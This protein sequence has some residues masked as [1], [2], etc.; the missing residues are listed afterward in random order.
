MKCVEIAKGLA[1]AAAL[2]SAGCMWAADKTAK[3]TF[4]GDLM[5]Q[6]G[7]LEPYRT[8][9]GYDF[10]DVFR[11]LKPLFAAS[12][13]V[14]GNLETPIAPDDQDLTHARWE[15]CSPRAFAQAVKDAGV[16][17]VFT[18][19]NHCLDRGPAGVVRTLQALD[20]VGLRHTGTF[21]TKADSEKPEIVEVKGFRLGLL[22]YT[23]GS[24]AFSNNQYLD[25][26]NRHLVNFFQQ[27]ELSPKGA[28][29]WQRGDRE[30]AEAKAYEAWEKTH[31]PDNFTLPVYERQEPHD[32]ERAKIKADVARTKAAKPD[33][34]VV[35]MHTG[36]Q[37]NPEATKYT[38]E[39]TDFLFGCGVDLVAGSHEH[40]VHGGDFAGLAENRLATYSLGN[41]NGLNG[42]WT[43]PFG[44]MADYSIAWHLYLARGADGKARVEKT[45]FTVLKCVKDGGNRR[46]R[47]V[48]AAELYIRETDRVARRKLRADILETARRFCGRDFE[49][50][51]VALEYP[52]SA[53]VRVDAQVPAG[54][55]VV[56]KVEGD[57]VRVRPDLRD[58]QG[59]WFY[60]AFRVTGAA[61]RKLAFKFGGAYKG[62]VVGTR[63]PVVSFDKGRT[64]AYACE[65]TCTQTGFTYAF[66]QDADEVW[67]YECH[68]YH[69]SDWEAFLARHA[70]D[71]GK[72]F[73]TGVLC[74]TKKGRAVEKARFGCL[75]G[76]PKYTMLLTSRHHASESVATYALEGFLEAVLAQDEL[77]AWLRANVEV[78]TVPFMDKD[79]CVDGDQGKN[80]KPHDHNRDYTEFLHPETKATVAWIKERTDNRLDVWIDLH[81]P[82]IRGPY[83][84]FVYSPLKR[85][86]NKRN[87]A[88]EIRF[89][90]L[91]EKLQCGSLNYKASDDLPYGKAWNTG[92]NYAKGWSSINWA[93]NTLPGIRLG[94]TFEIPFAT[95]N[96]ATVTPD[97]VRAL[98]RDIAKTLKAFLEAQ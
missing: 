12:D 69:Q 91:L 89:D 31:C 98:G 49:T 72:A 3:I 8:S 56:E 37:Y 4:V 48:P 57:T 2:L 13:Y 17:F 88:A 84:E 10:S 66:P 67:F 92:G 51:G 85:D 36:G 29:A 75:S 87:A 68:P 14:V 34:T 18:A 78:M 45:T 46:L 61:G 32:A 81:C 65:Q 33:F 22:A 9:S 95:A 1:M 86:V 90:Q 82:W 54:N 19:N 15:F 28:R 50:L 71:R 20:A 6:G 25:D 5:C 55:V 58:T 53:P 40:V 39:L 27:Q 16:D 79:G 74:T 38:K 59:D 93:L 24:N 44:K 43:P 64:W 97:R 76:K 26:S 7:L 73:E 83:N 62:A 94:H 41:V 30:S 63:G 60:W 21:A 96:G 42:V 11:D 47:T 35:G 70:A 23:Y 80:R 77:G 52:V